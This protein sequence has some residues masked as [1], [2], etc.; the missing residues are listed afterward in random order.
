MRLSVVPRERTSAALAAFFSYAARTIEMNARDDV[1]PGI[2]FGD[3]VIAACAVV[4]LGTLPMLD[5]ADCDQMERM[6]E[7][8]LYGRGVTTLDVINI[9]DGLA[10]E[11]TP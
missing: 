5:A 8:H 10:A 3:A 4:N 1:P 6:L 2:L 7:R 9:L 11:V